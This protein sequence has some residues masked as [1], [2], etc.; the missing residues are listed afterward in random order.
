MS[1]YIVGVGVWFLS[2]KASCYALRNKNKSVL[3]TRFI[4]LVCYLEHF[5]LSEL[6]A[7]QHFMSE[8]QWTLHSGLW[9]LEN[10]AHHTF[11][12]SSL[13]LSDLPRAL[14]AGA[15]AS[16]RPLSFL[17]LLLQ[18]LQLSSLPSPSTVTT[19]VK[20]SLSPSPKALPSSKTFHRREKKYKKTPQ[21]NT[22]KQ[23][24]Q[25]N[26]TKNL[27]TKKSRFVVH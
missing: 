11:A 9:P 23:M 25:N 2:Q 27:T 20:R 16:K 19:K 4:F 7:V 12:F 8:L 18:S 22:H 6:Q 17:C 13:L 3:N 24:E 1:W 21:T 15:A 26:P 14:P 5:F 10:S